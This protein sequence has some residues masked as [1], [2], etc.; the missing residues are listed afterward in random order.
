MSN[1]H[2]ERN[3]IL[4][5][6]EAVLVNEFR[7]YQS[8]RDLT[9]EERQV[10][11]EGQGQNLMSL[12]DKKEEL[13]DELTQMESKR[14]MIIDRIM[15]IFDVEQKHENLGE[16]LDAIKAEPIKRLQRLR[17]GLVA[18]QTEIRDINR[19]NSALASL[20]LEKISQLQNYLF[21]LFT[22][23]TQYQPVGNQAYADGPASWGMDQ[24][25]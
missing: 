10:L 3:E 4:V 14:N 7:V 6:L 9:L 16:L 2:E 11:L 15:D 21:K 24:R 18:L 25:A 22:S 23:T 19:G 8:L 13:L 1:N 17:Q 20:N 5:S 12:V